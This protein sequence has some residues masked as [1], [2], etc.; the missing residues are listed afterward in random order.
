MSKAIY[1]CILFIFF[2]CTTS[3]IPET[4]ISEYV[5][6]SVKTG[7]QERERLINKFRNE[8]EGKCVKRDIMGWFCMGKIIEINEDGFWYEY[9]PGDMIVKVFF[10]FSERTEIGPSLGNNIHT[11]AQPPNEVT[12]YHPLYGHSVFISDKDT[13]MRFYGKLE[14]IYQ[15]F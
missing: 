12:K 9:D 7:P 6:K 3:R 11:L 13:L 8:F 5:P 10:F 1:L 2:G 4:E 14:A 15:T